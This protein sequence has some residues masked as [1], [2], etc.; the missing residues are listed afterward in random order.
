MS[1]TRCA[2]TPT[3][4][5][6]VD[7][8]TRPHP[9]GTS[10]RRE[11]SFDDRAVPPATSAHRTATEQIIR[12]PPF[13][14]QAHGE[15]IIRAFSTKK[16][17]RRILVHGQYI[18]SIKVDDRG[19]VVHKWTK[20]IVDL[21]QVYLV[22]KDNRK[23]Y[24]LALE[25]A[26]RPGEKKPFTDVLQ[27]DP[28]TSRHF[29][30]IIST[31][32][33]E[34]LKRNAGGGSDSQG[35]P[36]RFSDKH[37]EEAR[38][39]TQS[40]FQPAPAAQTQPSFQPA[41]ASQSNAFASAIANAQNRSNP[42]FQP[43]PSAADPFAAP[44]SFTPSAAN[45]AMDPF[46]TQVP[47]PP[48]PGP[49]GASFNGGGGPV[50]S[51]GGQEFNQ[52][53]QSVQANGHQMQTLFSTGGGAVADPFAQPAAANDPFAAPPP[54][55]QQA[56]DPFNTATALNDPFAQQP[57]Q[58]NQN[59]FGAPQQQQQQQQQQNFNPFA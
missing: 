13:P 37:R 57:P 47:L 58:M 52:M 41:G 2:P 32:R 22:V 4:P 26:L 43:A 12:S 38:V 48:S 39:Q 24:Q 29:T 59:P 54:Q 14:R 28:A 49:G 34:L 5:H 53:M 33:K 7:R 6:Q 40:S 30:Q 16:Y 9:P 11:E 27:F 46:Q 44:P 15:A 10:K 36:Q 1:A 55:M 31:T 45:A 20:K 51:S 8:G 23:I 3:Q 56:R 25:F 19:F 18:V 21:K 42:M 17:P 35:A 50:S